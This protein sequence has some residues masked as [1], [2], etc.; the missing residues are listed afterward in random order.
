ML[1]LVYNCEKYDF[2]SVGKQ[3]YSVDTTIELKEDASIADVMQ[4]T[5]DMLK[6]AGYNVER[7]NIIKATEDAFGELEA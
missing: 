6:I 4:A 1:K 2:G 5:I 3:P 7:E